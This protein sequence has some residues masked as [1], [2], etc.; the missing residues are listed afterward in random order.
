MR[1]MG[2]ADGEQ[3]NEQQRVTIFYRKNKRVVSEF[4]S[5]R[6]KRLYRNTKLAIFKPAFQFDR[7]T[8]ADPLFELCEPE[9]A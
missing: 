6:F 5:G 9:I 7:V 8:P 1:L 2:I 4:I 3:N